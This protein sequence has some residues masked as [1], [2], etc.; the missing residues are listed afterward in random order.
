MRSARGWRR[1]E[2]PAHLKQACRHRDAALFW[3][4]ALR[5]PATSPAPASSLRQLWPIAVPVVIALAYASGHLSWYLTTPLGRV[6]VLDEHENLAL[7]ES[8]FRG[9]LPTEPFYRAS[10]YALVLAGFR[11][12]GVSASGLFPVA[13]ALGA[14]LHAVNAGLVALLARRWFG[15]VA[16]LL[17][18]LLFALN[19][20]LVHYA[21]QALDATPALTLFLT[22]LV[23]LAPELASL[24]TENRRALRW[25]GASLAWAAA[26]LLRPNYL[27]VWLTLPLLAWFA[28]RGR[29]KTNR[30]S[31][32]RVTFGVT[33]AWVGVALSGVVLFLA[34]AG[35]QAS[36][37]GTVGFL[38]WQGAYNLWAA[39][40]PGSN[41]RYFMQHVSL[42]PALAETNPARAES[43]LLY[44][45]ETGKTPGDIFAMNNHWRARFIGY[46][47]QHPFAWFGQLA[48]KTYALLNNWEQYNNKTFAFHQARSPWLRWNFLSWGVVFILGTAGAARLIAE[49][50][51]TA[52]SLAFLTGAC[53]ISIGLFFVSARF[54]LPLAA[55]ATVLAG[56][57]LGAPD[58]WRTWSRSRQLALAGMLVLA[59][60]LTFSNFDGVKDRNTFVQDHALLAHAASTVGDDRLA[61]HEANAALGLQETHPDALRIAV[62]SYFN[63]LLDDTARPAE[64]LL[65]SR[66]CVDLLNDAHVDAPDLR[67]VATLAVWR[68][69]QHET[70]LE[71]WRHLGHT[72]SALAARALVKDPSVSSADFNAL[73]GEAWA[74]PLVRL[75]AVSL[76]ISPPSG[77]MLDPP[78]QVARQVRRLFYPTP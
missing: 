73:S 71:L 17:A 52:V 3:S 55:I 56:G 19:P 43:M 13:L 18:G 46:V 6:P 75:A 20:V 31:G 12:L 1:A 40:R 64:T 58:F 76:D 60:L 74:Q 54:R 7:A 50:P 8:I 41:G 77:V 30:G 5:M 66:A 4:I 22:G 59:G 10:G 63:Q 57:A 23:F 16:A 39:N 15:P 35:W 29:L 72:P 26:T 42:P 2:R 62:A 78:A 34:M 47:V 68:S 45:M 21:T 14:V 44:Q 36:V 48:R 25:T 38:P 37:S 49:S 33:S 32:G 9:T 65:W 11:S 28:I 53:A 70:A 69:G 61:W 24:P 67:A 51:R 27:L